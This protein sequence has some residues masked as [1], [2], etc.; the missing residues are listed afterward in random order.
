MIRMRYRNSSQTYSADDLKSRLKTEKQAWLKE[1]EAKQKLSPEELEQSQTSEMKT[2]LAQL[3][4]ELTR[5]DLEKE[6]A[7]SLS[8]DGFP[9]ALLQF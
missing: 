3:E 6:A 1:Y 4:S 2:K 9:A 5:R 8:K 7:Q